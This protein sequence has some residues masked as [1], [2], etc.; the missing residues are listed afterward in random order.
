M[1]I[2]VIYC[3][4]H[5]NCQRNIQKITCQVDGGV[6]WGEVL[7]FDQDLDVVA[8][9]QDEHGTGTAIPVVIDLAWIV[10]GS[11]EEKVAHKEHEKSSRKAPN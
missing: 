4:T 10:D 11:T 5:P 8:S 2:H 9:D 1:S 3:I 6:E 7:G